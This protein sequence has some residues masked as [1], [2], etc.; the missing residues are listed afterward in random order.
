MQGA[1]AD[2]SS[3][4]SNAISRF[5]YRFNISHSHSTP[6]VE[7]GVTPPITTYCRK[8]E[9]VTHQYTCADGQKFSQPFSVHCDG[10]ATYAVRTACPHWKGA[11]SCVLSDF[12]LLSSTPPRCVVEK[13]SDSFTTCLCHLC[14]NASDSSRSSEQRRLRNS[15]T[16]GSSSTAA[17]AAAAAPPPKQQQP[18][19]RPL[20]CPPKLS[21]Q[22]LA[23][24]SL[25][26]LQAPPCWR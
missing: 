17:E 22:L 13:T 16:S 18:Y 25:P 26:S 1:V 9:I 21:T 11:T 3:D 24:P 8:G 10:T 6:L 19:A 2:C 12:R 4:R 7:S 23:S 15:R 5:E 14:N 20:L